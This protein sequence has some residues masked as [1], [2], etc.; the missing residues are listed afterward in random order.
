[1]IRTASPKYEPRLETLYKES[2]YRKVP[3]IVRWALSEAHERVLIAEERQEILA[4]IYIDVCGYNNLWSS[5]LAFKNETAMKDLIDY[6]ME[7]RKRRGLRNFYFFCPKEFVNVRAYLI[8]RG[9]VPECIRKLAGIEYIVEN[10]DGTFDQNYQIPSP[11]EPLP[12]VLR[13]GRINDLESLAEILHKSL[14]E[15]FGTL[16]AATKCVQKWLTEMPE[17]IIVA[18]HNDTAIGVVL[19]SLEISPVLD[20]NMAMLCF[21]A[22]DERFRRRGVGKAL[23]K[24]ACEILK[25]KGKDSM[26]VDTGA[27]NIPARIFYT[28]TGFYPFWFSRNYMPHDN[29]I[30]YRIDF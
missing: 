30:F 18:H 13:R 17:Y 28:K 11:K 21:L 6:L 27:H 7:T 4:S 10:H 2:R 3:E 26:E 19:V 24:K 1:M 12:I 16:K 15:D 25:G 29:G 14:P 9:F 8:S 23:V 22:V 5:Y 20:R